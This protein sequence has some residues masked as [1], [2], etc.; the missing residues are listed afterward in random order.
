MEKYTKLLFFANDSTIGINKWL[1]KFATCVLERKPPTISMVYYFGS[2]GR[3]VSTMSEMKLSARVAG[4]KGRVQRAGLDSSP[5]LHILYILF[6]FLSVGKC[7]V[8][9][10][11]NVVALSLL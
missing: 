5:V 1:Q 8:C 2:Y 6:L 9:S 7:N 10:H 4:L 11:C 3:Y